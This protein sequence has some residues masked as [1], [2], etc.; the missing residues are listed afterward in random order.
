MP[1]DRQDGCVS[2]D[3]TSPAG[4]CVDGRGMFNVE[5]AVLSKNKRFIYTNAYQDP[6]LIAVLNRNL[7]TGELSQRSGRRPASA[8]TDPARTGPTPA[9]TA[10][11]SRRLR[12]GPRAERPDS[13]L[14]RVQPDA[15]VVFRVSTKTGAIQPAVRQGR[16]CKPRRLER[17]RGGDLRKGARD[18]RRVSG[19]ARR[20]GAR[21]LRRLL[22]GQ[23]RRPAQR[24]PLS[25]PPSPSNPARCSPRA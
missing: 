24:R 25:R 15:L 17:G 2:D 5:R 10:G 6:R 12:R 1:L 23:R 8:G 19:R 14:R 4:P 7:K 22:R 11:R 13:L 21:R 16:L 18:R 3:G 20:Q 9:G